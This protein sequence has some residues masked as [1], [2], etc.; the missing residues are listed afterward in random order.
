LLALPGLWLLR[1]EWAF[2]PP[3]IYG[4]LL[5]LVTSLI[6]PAPSLTGAFYNTFG[7]IVPFLALAAAYALQ[8]GLRRLLRAP[9][10]SQIGLVIAT[11]GLLLLAGAQAILGL[12]SVRD[13]NQAHSARFEMAAGWLDQHAA[14]GDMLMA[15]QPYLLHYASGYPCIALPAAEPPQAAFQAAQRYGAR[16]LVLTQSLGRYPQTLDA[17]PD[18]HFRLLERDGPIAIYAIERDGP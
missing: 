18:P 4:L 5:F 1:S 14:P 10:L 11:A 15:T 7:A 9:R 8:R 3:V 6:F 13:E 12:Q 2:W 16:F 17:Q